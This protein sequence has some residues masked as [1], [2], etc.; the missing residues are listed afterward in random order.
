VPE[1]LTDGAMAAP[2]PALRGLIDHYLGYHFS[3]FEPG[4]HRGLPSGE[5]TFI[6]SLDEPVDA[7]ALPDQTQTPERLT[8]FAGGLAGAP[9]LIRHDGTQFGVSIGLAPL[10]TRALFGMP[11]AALAWTTVPL[12]ML[13]GPVANQLEDRL[14]AATGWSARF[15]VLDDVL[16]R[17]LREFRT[18]APE[19][20]HAWTCLVEGHGAIGVGDLATEV[21]W[22]RRHLT[23]RFRDE[24][25]LTPKVMA[26]VLRFDRARHMLQRTDAPSIAEVAATCGYFDQ[27]HLTREWNELAGCSPTVWL[28]GELPSVQD[29]LAGSDAC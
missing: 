21:G 17:A 8:A 4:L 16:T 22:S 9:A 1:Q 23:Q 29:T 19:V 10:G 20:A 2:A 11:A 28:A 24:V 5:M 18:P 25:G 12:D 26:R 14:R 13:L 3:G 6:I 15:G 7:V 27:A